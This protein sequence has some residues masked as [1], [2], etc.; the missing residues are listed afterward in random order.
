MTYIE[1][2]E[3]AT[4]ACRQIFN[5]SVNVVFRIENTLQIKIEFKD[6]FM[7][8]VRVLPVRTTDSKRFLEFFTNSNIPNNVFNEY[9][10]NFLISTK[11][12]KII[13]WDAFTEKS[14]VCH[15]PPEEI[16]LF[17]Q[18]LND[19]IFLVFGEDTTLS[20]S[21]INRCQL[22][23]TSSGV[24]YINSTAFREAVFKINETN[25]LFNK[26]LD[27]NNDLE[28]IE[29]LIKFLK[30]SNATSIY[31]WDS[32]IE[33]DLEAT[34]N[35]E[36]VSKARKMLKEHYK[37]LNEFFFEDYIKW[38]DLLKEDKE[39]FLKFWKE[40]ISTVLP[41]IK[42][43]S[44]LS[45][46]SKIKKEQEFPKI[47]LSTTTASVSFSN[48]THID[49]LSI[50]INNKELNIVKNTKAELKHAIEAFTSYKELKNYIDKH[51]QKLLLEFTSSKYSEYKSI[52]DCERKILDESNYRFDAS[53]WC[54]IFK[55]SYLFF[56]NM[57][58]SFNFIDL[59]FEE[60]NKIIKSEFNKMVTKISN[61]FSKEDNYYTLKAVFDNSKKGITTYISIL[62]GETNSK[63]RDYGYDKSPAYGKL[64]QYTKKEIES[65]IRNLIQD[66]L[67]VEKNFRASFG[68]YIG[69]EVS[70]ELI[71]YI[72]KSEVKQEEKKV[73]VELK[74]DSVSDFIKRFIDSDNNNRNLIIIKSLKENI[75]SINQVDIQNMI[76]FI[77]GNRKLYRECEKEIIDL[78]SNITPS[79]YKTLYLLNA[80]LSN[81]V[82]KD[83][84][85]SIYN[86]ISD[87]SPE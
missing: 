3:R 39:D 57:E 20:F 84:F 26:Y 10:Y 82:L 35:K 73:I 67:I 51:I 81:G 15:I 44:K 83:M 22:K 42:D 72:K 60:L 64:S 21:C 80:N 34:F 85:T 6:K 77:K 36:V 31:N 68:N 76:D 32:I 29:L 19:Y 58:F 87:D 69:L 16:S 45:S 66:N 11:S 5:D 47:I 48:K 23:L 78:F 59:H 49:M 46:Y 70:K 18:R 1:L 52:Y 65:I 25:E 75:Q 7:K 28:F 9:I 30:T 43:L 61:S 24:I 33:Y 8:K 79:K 17:V 54:I 14:V 41:V 40:N 86:S 4:N 63:I 27:V 62:K 71:D 38:M 53:R 50:K 37:D 12:T 13:N 55:N 74:V 56:N 2:M